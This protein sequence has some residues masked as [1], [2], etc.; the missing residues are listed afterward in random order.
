[1]NDNRYELFRLIYHLIPVNANY[2]GLS[3][4]ES[5]ESVKAGDY[6]LVIYP[7]YSSFKT[8]GGKLSVYNRSFKVNEV[9]KS[10]YFSLMEVVK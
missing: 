6:F 3:D 1:M 2:L 9:G 5:F 4:E 8:M 7:Q 10:S